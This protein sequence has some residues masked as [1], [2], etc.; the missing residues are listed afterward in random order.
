MQ[1]IFPISTNPYFLRNDKIFETSNVRTVYCGT[2]TISFLG[3]KT[4]NLL[5]DR[6]KD[7]TTLTQFKS[8]IRE[9]VPEGC[10]CRL[11]KYY[12]PNLD[13]I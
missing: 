13:F 2:E 8:K 10:V 1:D 4:W 9:W 7:S 11:C 5:P 12:V 3:P 6:I